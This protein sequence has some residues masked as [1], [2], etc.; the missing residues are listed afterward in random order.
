MRRKSTEEAI[1]RS[2]DY[3]DNY[4]SNETNALLVAK[5]AAI[6]QHEL[7]V[8]LVREFAEVKA[9]LKKDH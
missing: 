1:E 6:A 9:L 7:L 8:A 4:L 2:T 3:I 5:Y